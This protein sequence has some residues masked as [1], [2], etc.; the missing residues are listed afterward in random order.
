MQ[1]LFNETISWM[2]SIALYVYTQ[3]LMLGKAVPQCNK[4]VPLGQGGGPGG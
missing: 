3:L 4:I 1:A 2:I